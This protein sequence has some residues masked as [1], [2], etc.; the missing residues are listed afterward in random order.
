M[1]ELL[2]ILFWIGA[3]SGGLLIILLLISIF[4]GMEIGGDLDVDVDVDMDTDFDG[5]SG[6]SHFGLVKTILTFVSV[7]AFTA[8][9]FLMNTSWSGIYVTLSAL[10][11][12]VVAVLLLTWFFK[13]LLKNQEEGNWHIWEAEGKVGTVYIPVPAKGKG[14]II[15]PINGVNR[16][17]QAKSQNDFAIKSRQKVLVIE[18]KDDFVV[19]VP[20]D[21]EQ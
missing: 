16:E 2:I 13:W 15:V 18:T 19:V 3:A 4:S 9:A 11:A 12:G 5:A 21:L 6:D 17:I 14:R 8:R 1:Q 7:G 10:F 20:Y